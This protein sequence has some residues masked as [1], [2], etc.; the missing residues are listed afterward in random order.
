MRSIICIIAS[1]ILICYSY[2]LMTSI[3]VLYG[4]RL[5]CETYVLTQP[6]NLH[7]KLFG[8]LG[9]NHPGNYICLVSSGSS[10][11]CV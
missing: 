6:C 3:T 4:C 11:D 8:L 7:G 1:D 5:S 2:K 9:G 10:W